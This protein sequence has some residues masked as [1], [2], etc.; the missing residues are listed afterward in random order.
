MV[1]LNNCTPEDMEKAAER[2]RDIIDQGY[3]YIAQPPLY[4]VT[5]GKSE[6]YL[7]DER[8]LEDYLIST[9]I[10]ECVF[11]PVSGAE[12]LHCHTGG[13]TPVS[14]ERSVGSMTTSAPSARLTG[15]V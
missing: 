6:T 10:D 1:I 5:R 2:M 9:G 13:G 4:K 14:A 7:K 11:K 12:R 15:V 3:L 8:A